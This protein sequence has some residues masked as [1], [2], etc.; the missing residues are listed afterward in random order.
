MFL[1]NGFIS[2]RRG[3]IRISFTGERRYK[4]LGKKGRE[5]R[6][7]L[8]RAHTGRSFFF[9]RMKCP[10]QLIFFFFFLFPF[11]F[12]YLYRRFGALFLFPS[13]GREMM[14]T[15]IGI[16]EKG[17]NPQ[18]SEKSNVQN[19]CGRVYESRRIRGYT[20]RFPSP[21]LFLHTLLHAI[22]YHGQLAR[23]REIIRAIINHG[24]KY[25]RPIARERKKG[26]IYR[27]G[28]NTIILI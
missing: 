17:T 6:K 7:S 20:D 16:L 3:L 14:S 5:R 8:T 13:V 26:R 22:V 2:P 12:F 27:F 9:S 23:P 11:F 18:R 4:K 19:Q 1:Q 21:S 10:V 24:V 15:A 25:R 28:K